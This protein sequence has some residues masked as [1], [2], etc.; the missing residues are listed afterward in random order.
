MLIYKMTGPNQKVEIGDKPSMKEG[1]V[2]KSH[3]ET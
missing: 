1:L 3:I 2:M